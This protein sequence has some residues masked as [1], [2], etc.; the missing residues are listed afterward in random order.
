ME[1]DTK[2]R[3]SEKLVSEVELTISSEMMSD[4]ANIQVRSPV[5]NLILAI[6]LRWSMCLKP[7]S[8]NVHWS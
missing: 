4:M 7:N 3:K 6:I 2:G 1:A 8:I 5:R